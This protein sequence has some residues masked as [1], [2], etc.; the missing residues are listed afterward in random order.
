MS[1]ASGVSASGES[2]GED[3]NG[4]TLHPARLYANLP[5]PAQP[6]QAHP[7]KSD[8]IP[9]MI[10]RSRT[11]RDPAQLAKMVVDLATGNA[12]PSD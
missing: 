7:S 6:L 2:Y 8:I 10:K 11:P 5:S 3:E 12:P 4:N 9:P 1:T